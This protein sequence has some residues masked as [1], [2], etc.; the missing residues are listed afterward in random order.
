MEEN[1]IKKIRTGAGMSQRELSERYGIPT[2]T[3]E[4]WETDKRTPPTYVV[5]LLARAVED[6]LKKRRQK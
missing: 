5:N 4:D 1:A 6:D 3:I 2:R